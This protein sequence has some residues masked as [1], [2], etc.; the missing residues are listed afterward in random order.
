M[1]DIN[2]HLMFEMLNNDIILNIYNDVKTNN[3][4]LGFFNISNESDF[5]NIVVDNIEFNM[6]RDDTYYINYE[7][8]S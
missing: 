1:T 4:Q 7:I 3:E 5:I 2:L 8:D 6:V